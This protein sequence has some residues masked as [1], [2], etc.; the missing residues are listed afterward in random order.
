METGLRGLRLRPSLRR[1]DLTGLDWKLREREYEEIAALPGL[2]RLDV[3]LQAIGWGERPLP[4]VSHLT[5]CNF[6]GT[7][8]LSVIPELF[9]DLR[10]V[11]VLLAPQ[12]A[13]VGRHIF[14]PLPVEPN[15]SRATRVV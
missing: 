6:R 11:E 2:T 9:P 4:G 1:L 13:R 3:D 15:V 14:A 8:D 7:E 5:F 10:T 12:A